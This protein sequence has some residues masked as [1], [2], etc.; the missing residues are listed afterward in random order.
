MNTTEIIEI[1]EEIK[2][3][4]EQPPVIIDA[5]PIKIKKVK[6][7]PAH[8]KKKPLWRNPNIKDILYFD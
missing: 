6:N 1:K 7:T 2:K 3:V 8:Y 4:D 5:P